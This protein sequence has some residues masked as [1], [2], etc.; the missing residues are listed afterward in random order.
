MPLY[1]NAEYLI[2]ANLNEIAGGRRVQ[3][4]VIGTLTDVQFEAINRQKESQ[5]LP[6][7][8]NPEI[9][10]LGRHAYESRV[11]RDGYTIDDMVVQIGFA[12]AETAITVASP[13]M[14]A[15]KSTQLRQDG[16]GNEVM[17][18]AIFELT[19][20]KPKAELYSIV[21]KGDRIKPKRQAK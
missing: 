7:L 15:V 6:Q 17:D 8:E 9:V 19:T 3:A 11:V 5:G 18:E 1:D 16:Y 12:L 14:T 13:R 10:F 2:R 4:V 21:P 20:R